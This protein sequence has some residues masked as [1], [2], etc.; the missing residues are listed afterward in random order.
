MTNLQEILNLISN[1]NI[2]I[3]NELYEK[4]KDIF[5][6]NKYS[7]IYAMKE[8][9]FKCVDPLN[10]KYNKNDSYKMKSWL[11]KKKLYFPDKSNMNQLFY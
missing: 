3:L 7:F 9:K 8:Y 11:L 1:G 4:E 2:K 10:S 6:K 5:E